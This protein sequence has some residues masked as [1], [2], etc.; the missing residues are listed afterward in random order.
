[1]GRRREPGATTQKRVSILKLLRDY[2]DFQPNSVP[3]APNPATADNLEKRRTECREWVKRFSCD[4][5]KTVAAQFSCVALDSLASERGIGTRISDRLRPLTRVLDRDAEELASSLGREAAGLPLTEALHFVTS[6]YPA[7]LPQESR[8]KLGAYYTPPAL[9]NRMVE[10]ATEHGTDWSTVRVLDPAAGAGAFLIQAASRMVAAS[11]GAEPAFVLRQLGAR[12][13]GLEID[14][15]AALLAQG[16]LEILLSDL[17]RDAGL[18]APRFVRVCDSIEERPDDRYDLVLGNPPYG[19]VSLTPE[20]RARF[21]RSLYGHA[22]LYG[23]F[24]DIALRWTK[25]GGLIAYLTPTS[26][27]AGQ[28]YSALRQLLADEAP[29]LSIDFVHARKDVFEDVLQETLLAVYKKD[30]RPTRARIH[31][32]NVVSAAG[33]TVTRN[34]TIGLPAKPSA[35]WLA[36][37]SPE[38]GRLIARAEQMPSRLRDLGYAVSTGPLVWNRFKSQLTHEAAGPSV[39]PL[40]WAECV[41]P[42]G[43]FE[44]R[45][46]KRNHTPFFRLKPGNE[47]L[48]VTRPCVLVQRTTAKEQPRRLIAAELPAELIRKHGGVVIENHLNMVSASEASNI[49]PAVVAAL[50]NSE[51]VDQLFRCMNGSVAVS[52]FELE[53]LP[54][55][56]AGDLARL[57]ELVCKGASRPEVEAECARLYNGIKG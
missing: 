41:L 32:L 55:P 11:G 5:G 51:V 39:H 13:Q 6:L 47:W 44:Y 40:I 53:S 1:M 20:R 12:L 56:G 14:P 21:S 3:D 26:F 54:I 31:Y 43:R 9:V 49:E 37:R 28:Y 15:H 29:P 22:N 57:E 38:H 52:A 34:G 10:L 25:P 50:L 33:A 46:R 30:S 23:L 2:P 42:E 17:I 18:A 36:P 7:L 27:L 35:P 24:T 48:V 8:S 4:Q 19:R 45:A 16:A